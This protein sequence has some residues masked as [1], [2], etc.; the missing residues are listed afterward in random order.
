MLQTETVEPGTLALLREIMTLK[1]LNQFNLVGGTN[2]SLR[3]GHRKS[4]DLDL[5]TNQEFDSGYLLSQL[6]KLF[7]NLTVITQGKIMLF[8]YIKGIKV[9]FVFIPFSYINPV[10]EIDEIRLASVQDVIAFKL[11]EIAVQKAKSDFWDLYDLLTHYSVKQM[12]GFFQEK[13]PNHDIFS[14]IRSLQYFSDADNQVDPQPLTKVS[15]SQIKV[16]IR[17]SVNGFIDDE[18]NNYPSSFTISPLSR[19]RILFTQ[20]GISSSKWVM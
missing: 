7:P 14:I 1:E 6:I 3:F 15:W 12:I 10:E 18:R 8:L 13:Y 11:N 16:K 4:I 17:N 2:L 20:A 19:C 9:D 5:F